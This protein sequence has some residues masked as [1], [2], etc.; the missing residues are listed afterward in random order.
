MAE[1]ESES[2]PSTHTH[3]QAKDIMVKLLKLPVTIGFTASDFSWHPSSL[4]QNRSFTWST[5]AG[6]NFDIFYYIYSSSKMY[7][8]P[9][10]P[11]N[12][13]NERE[14][15]FSDSKQG[16]RALWTFHYKQRYLIINWTDRFQHDQSWHL[17]YEPF[18]THLASKALHLYTDTTEQLVVKGLLQR[19]KRGNLAVLGWSPQT[20][21]NLSKVFNL[22]ATVTI[23]ELSKYD[24]IIT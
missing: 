13:I 8:C 23:A 17:P 19:P 24:Y 1:N 10:A 3:E 7:R 15:N 11:P 9:H 4:Q 20:F 14:G 21:C 12:P 5:W 16:E 22:W 18:Q 6:W 2:E